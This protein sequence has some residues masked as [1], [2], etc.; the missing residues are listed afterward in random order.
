[1]KHCNQISKVIGHLFP[2]L[3]DKIISYGYKTRD[4]EVP[5]GYKQNYN[6]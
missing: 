1:M 3:L 6:V 5:N 2:V 4:I